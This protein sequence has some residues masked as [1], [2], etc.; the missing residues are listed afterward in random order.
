MSHH[1][2]L[3][4]IGRHE[5]HERTSMRARI[6]ILEGEQMTLDAA[7]AGSDRIGKMRNE[8]AGANETPPNRTDRWMD[9]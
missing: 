1:L 9:G 6:R 8:R 7:V 4:S 5:A 2:S 3:M